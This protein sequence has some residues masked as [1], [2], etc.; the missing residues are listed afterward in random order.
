MQIESIDLV[1]QVSSG[2]SCYTIEA[3]QLLL[4]LF[5]RLLDRGVFGTGLIHDLDS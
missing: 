2:R 3:L 4:P 1:I 5:H